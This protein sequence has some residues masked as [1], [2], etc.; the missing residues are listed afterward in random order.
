[1]CWAFDNDHDDISKY[2]LCD[3]QY[4]VNPSKE[5]LLPE[6]LS[7]TGFK[8]LHMFLWNILNANDI[9]NGSRMQG[10]YTGGEIQFSSGAMHI[11]N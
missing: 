3:F 2:S 9:H 1:M 8:C 7:T 5:Y 4:N 6:I 10:P 11:F